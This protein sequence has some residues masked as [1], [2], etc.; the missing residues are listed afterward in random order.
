MLSAMR[1]RVLFVLVI[2]IIVL[3]DRT[4]H[5]QAQE[6]QTLDPL[7]KADHEHWPAVGTSERLQRMVLDAETHY[8]DH[9]WLSACRIFQLVISESGIEALNSSPEIRDHAAR[10]FHKCARLAFR[11]HDDQDV[12]LYLV[13]AEKLGLHSVRHEV[14]RRKLVRRQYHRRLAVADIDGALDLYRT[15]QASGPK[16][17]DERIWLGEQLANRAQE[18]LDTGN[19]ES[20]LYLMEHLEAIAPRNRDFRALKRAREKKRNPI[21]SAVSI[22]GISVGG[23]L[24]LSGFV[25]WIAWLRVY[26]A[27]RRHP[28]LKDDN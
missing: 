6:T 28:F 3:S 7:I 8:K 20:F 12:E 22:V 11:A 24:L 10:S 14:L 17:E 21:L 27:R 9:N 26:L 5:A 18:A 23:V 1:T 25:T 13:Q 2:T 15:Y 16:D 19:Q 4:A